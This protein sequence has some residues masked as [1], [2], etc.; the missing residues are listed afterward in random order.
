MKNHLKITTKHTTQLCHLSCEMENEMRNI[1]KNK[2]NPVRELG[3]TKLKVSFTDLPTPR[4][5]RSE[6]DL[7]QDW[8]AGVGQYL[9][10]DMTLI[11]N[12]D[13]LTQEEK[14]KKLEP[15]IERYHIGPDLKIWY[16]MD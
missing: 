3:D 8:W 1:V 6:K 12:D 11:E 2:I 10:E 13:K 9:L 7:L 14:D 5:T 15:L 4:D 16:E